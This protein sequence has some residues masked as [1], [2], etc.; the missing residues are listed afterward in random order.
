MQTIAQSGICRSR[1]MFHYLRSYA[2]GEHGQFDSGVALRQRAR[3]D[4]RGCA[5]RADNRQIAFSPQGGELVVCGPESM[6]IWDTE[7]LADP[8]EIHDTHQFAFSLTADNWRQ[9]DPTARSDCGIC[10]DGN[11]PNR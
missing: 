3:H 5:I 8:F 1:I 2:P 6:A 4:H 7:I 11:W 10:R 9:M